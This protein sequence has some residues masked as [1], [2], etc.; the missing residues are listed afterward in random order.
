MTS[1]D[2]CQ[3]DS[4]N[5]LPRES[6]LLSF[7]GSLTQ[8]ACFSSHVMLQHCLYLLSRTIHTPGCCGNSFF[9]FFFTQWHQYFLSKKF[10]SS[11][12]ANTSHSLFFIPKCSL[13]HI[14]HPSLV[15]VFAAVD[16]FSILC[17]IL[18]YWFLSLIISLFALV[19]VS[20][21]QLCMCCMCFVQRVV[22][23]SGGGSTYL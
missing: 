1:H 2:F 3:V 8:R 10:Q 17:L 15:F 4:N 7:S 18:S 5:A 11:D 16:L 9:I 19:S 12:N 23:L 22:R 6:G 21:S 14:F 13:I 20:A